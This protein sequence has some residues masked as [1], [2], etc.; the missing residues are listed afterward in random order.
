MSWVITESVAIPVS[1][2]KRI[3]QRK[4]E[5]SEQKPSFDFTLGQ[6]IK[7]ATTK[8][9]LRY[10]LTTVDD[11]TIDVTDSDFISIKA[12]LNVFNERDVQ[13]VEYIRSH[14]EIKPGTPVFEEI[15]RKILG[16]NV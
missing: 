6:P 11:K 16:A 8:I 14:F 10:I 13:F 15:K 4:K 12:Q 2:I 7:N 1:Q 5:Q 9:P 3:E